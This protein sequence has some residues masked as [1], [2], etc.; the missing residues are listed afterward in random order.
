MD[1]KLIALIAEKNKLERLLE[2]TDKPFEVK[3]LIASVDRRI[4]KHKFT[5]KCSQVKN[6]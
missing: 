6:G 4:V 5:L 3:G 1:K 2:R